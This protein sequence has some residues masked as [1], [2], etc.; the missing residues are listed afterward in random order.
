MTNVTGPDVPAW[1]L[2]Y[3]PAMSP[4]LL[5]PEAETLL[6]SDLT[7]KEFHNYVYTDPADFWIASSTRP[8]CWMRLGTIVY[9]SDDGQTEIAN[10][11]CPKWTD[12]G[13]YG[14][15]KMLPNMH[16]T[17]MKNGWSRC[18]AKD[19]WVSQA[20]HIFSRLRTK[21]P[22]GDCYF[23]N[24]ISY[25]CR[26]SP[27][28]GSIPH[29]YL[30]LC[31]LGDLSTFSDD[32]LHFRQPDNPG[33]WSLHPDGTNP[34]S[35]RA[36]QSLGFPLIELRIRVAGHAWTDTAYAALRRFHLGKCFDGQSQDVARHL[37]YPLY[38]LAEEHG[39]NEYCP[40]PVAVLWFTGAR[41]AHDCRGHSF[42]AI[43]I[44]DLLFLDV[45]DD[46]EIHR[47]AEGSYGRRVE[48]EPHA[49]L[50]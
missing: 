4:M 19:V 9:C 47:T 23:I 18:G 6:I 35:R 10:V 8:K 32:R 14:G 12:F 31:P 44:A 7:L 13:W 17:I 42:D 45:G 22:Y 50:L 43:N 48:I 3:R 30:F 26:L 39:A 16:P 36:A 38:E 1:N 20:N 24:S 34:L 46:F 5:A 25:L 29:G 49:S 28:S 2:D 37:G 33:F 15:H 40:P 11:A 27:T 21:Y 41:W